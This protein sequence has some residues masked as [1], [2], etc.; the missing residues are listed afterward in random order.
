MNDLPHDLDLEL[1]VLGCAIASPHGYHLASTVVIPDDFHDPIHRDIWDAC[2][3]APVDRDYGPAIG[4][5]RRDRRIAHVARVADVRRVRIEEI[6][7]SRPVMFGYMPPKLV[8]VPGEKMIRLAELGAR[9]RQILDLET[10]IGQLSGA[11]S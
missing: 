1:F 2:G 8:D 3:S 9:R 6:V 7:F 4:T 10:T 5:L 11:V